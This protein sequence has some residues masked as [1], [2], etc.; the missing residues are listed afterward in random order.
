MKCIL[1]RAMSYQTRG[2]T[3]RAQQGHP[4]LSWVLTLST[5]DLIGKSRSHLICSFNFPH[6][7]LFNP[8][9]YRAA[10]Q[11]PTHD[12]SVMTPNEL[13]SVSTDFHSQLISR[14]HLR[15]C[16]P[17]FWS[18]W[19]QVTPDIWV[20]SLLFIWLK[21]LGLQCNKKLSIFISITAADDKTQIRPWH[22]LRC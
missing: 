3:G 22:W 9:T 17:K 7:T 18:Y 8:L 6:W 5:L 11:S 13:C 4:L 20:Y 15:Q 12:L 21:L 19:L 1:T 10:A 2:Y 16:L 14:I